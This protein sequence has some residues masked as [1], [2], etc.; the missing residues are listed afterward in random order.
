MKPQAVDG[1]IARRGK[2]GRAAFS[3]AELMIALAVL[4]MGLLVIGASL[5][6]G[7]QY[8]RDSANLAMGDACVDY[9]Q[10]AIGQSLNLPHQILDGGAL[11]HEPGLFLP[12]ND[13]TGEV[14]NADAAPIVYPIPADTNWY[15]P[16]IKARPLPIQ[17][18]DLTPGSSTYEQQ[19]P[20]NSWAHRVAEDMIRTWGNTVFLMSTFGSDP[21]EV[22]QSTGGWP[23]IR[24]SIACVSSVYPPITLDESFTVRDFM[25]SG[26]AAKY[27][28]AP[29]LNRFSGNSEVEKVCER[30]IAWTAFYRRVSYAPGSDP[31]LYEIITV[32]VRKQ[33]KDHRFPVQNPTAQI[34]TGALP[35]SGFDSATP[36]PWLVCFTSLPTPSG[37]FDS[38]GSGYPDPLTV[39]PA[40]LTFIVAI[41]KAPLFREGTVFFPARNDD[42]PSIVGLRDRP[43]EQ[44]GFSPPAPASLPYYEVT[45]VIENPSN[46][47]AA[48]VVKFNGFYPRKGFMNATTPP[49]VSW[50]VW[51]IPPAFDTLDG[52]LNP[53]F[54]DE[55]PILAVRSRFV[56][57]P[58]IE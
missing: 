40:E 15:E 1:M 30:K 20:A 44:V 46:G 13:V 41:D 34:N 57:L 45:K 58:M 56:R 25:N 55:S 12:R 29:A 36:I 35:Y 39:D 16:V 51:V 21:A 10:D 28:P 19:I 50:P 23:W 49:P 52:N 8:T 3:L 24:P 9:A 4:G 22:D 54:P 26:P 14:V 5:P 47:N 37:G 53:V 33:S 48:V 6:V 17:N 11:D 27:Q 2:R 43:E 18:V 42:N 38:D 7:A 32:A 31:S